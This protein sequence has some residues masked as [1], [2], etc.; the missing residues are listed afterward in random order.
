MSKKDRRNRIEDFKF[1]YGKFNNGKRKLTMVLNMMA[2]NC[3]VYDGTE[4]KWMD[5]EKLEKVNNRYTID[6]CPRT[7]V[8]LEA[9]RKIVDVEYYNN[10]INSE[11]QLEII[12]CINRIDKRLVDKES[13][14]EST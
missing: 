11:S 14:G 10:K 3:T 13:C 5:V 9:L 4:R 7:D 8:L 12:D 2:E 1:V 6:I